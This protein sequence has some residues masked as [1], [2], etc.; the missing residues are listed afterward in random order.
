M[1]TSRLPEK[2]EAHCTGYQQNSTVTVISNC[3]FFFAVQN[4]IASELTV[5]TVLY[6]TLPAII[7]D[8]VHQL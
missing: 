8:P 6:S 5:P 2:L 7:G 4:I 1:F 3:K